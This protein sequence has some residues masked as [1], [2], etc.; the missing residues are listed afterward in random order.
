MFRFSTLARA[1][2]NL[3][4]FFGICG[5]QCGFVGHCTRVGH[6]SHV[7]TL[8]GSLGRIVS[9]KT[10]NL[11]GVEDLHRCIV[12]GVLSLC[13]YEILMQS[14]QGALRTGGGN[15]PILFCGAGCQGM[16]MKVI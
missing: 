7:K 16:V 15:H 8:L 12:C 2:C 9:G 3:L 10:R 13:D 11:S 6:R 4:G 1:F 5:Q 14:S